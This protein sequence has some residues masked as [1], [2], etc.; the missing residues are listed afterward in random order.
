VSASRVPG[1]FDPCDDRTAR[2]AWSRL[3]EPGDCA[4]TRCLHTFGAGHALLALMERPAQLGQALG[5]HR[6]VANWRSRLSQVNPPRDLATVGRFG[7]RLVIPGDAEWPCAMAGLAE[8]EPVSLWVRGPMSLGETA[9]RSVAMVGCRACSRY[10]EWAATELA[11]GCAERRITVV[12]GAAY[13]IDAAAHRGA[14][15]AGG[16]T[17]AV[18]AC[19]VDRAYPRGN[20]DLIERIASTHS[21]VSEVPPGSS[22][23]RWRFLTRNR[24][25]AALCQVTVVVEAAWRSG[26]SVT[27]R[28][29]A[30]LGRQVAAVPGPV[31]SST[32]AG[33]HRLLREGA[34][35]V[36]DA[37][38]VA[39]LL[40]A[41]GENPAPVRPT[42]VAEHDGLSP[43]DL[44]VLDALPVRAAVGVERL[45]VTAGVDRAPL[46]SSLA[47]L[48]LD[49]L[50]V[51]VRTAW[52]RV[53][54]R[55]PELLL[56]T[57]APGRDQGEQAG[58]T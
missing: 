23:T 6:P 5:D 58:R 36:T 55:P 57:P 53:P 3:A 11:S 18:L 4:V 8:R 52:R 38:E 28:E 45:A 51:R 56:G 46:L 50:A 39:E 22:P 42:P 7:G 30:Q 44:R 12:S 47:R 17:V 33:C 31:T 54:V 20:E 24:L 1:W 26:T 43:V 41:I 25:I 13:G 10:G 37:A 40:G 2:A 14:L 35:C 32:S 27:A 19:G 49:G 29:A 34:V 9:N 16:S 48:E 15:S 21:L